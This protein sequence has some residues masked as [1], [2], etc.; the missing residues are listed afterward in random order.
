MGSILDNELKELLIKA[1]LLGGSEDSVNFLWDWS[2]FTV[3]S[4]DITFP[5]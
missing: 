2:Q 5:M 1:L 4:E 3:S